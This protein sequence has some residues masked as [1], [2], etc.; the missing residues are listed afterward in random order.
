MERK[1]KPRRHALAVAALFRKAGAHRKSNKARRRAAKI[2]IGGLAQLVEQGTFN[3]QAAGSIP[4]TA[5]TRAL[6]KARRLL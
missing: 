2:H 1:P 3:P 4:A 5:T 6:T